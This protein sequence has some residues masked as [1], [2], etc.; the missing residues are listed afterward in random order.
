MLNGQ[1]DPQYATINGVS[2]TMFH[3]LLLETNIHQVDS[4]KKLRSG[5][6]LSTL[7]NRCF[8]AL[9]LCAFFAVIHIFV[10]VN[11]LQSTEIV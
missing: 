11:R 10:C 4:G 6:A 8:L 3:F 7:N 5:S 9:T 2:L 1:Y